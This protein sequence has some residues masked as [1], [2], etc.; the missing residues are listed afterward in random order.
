[1]AKKSRDKGKLGE[2]DLAHYLTRLGFPARRT[3]QF[4]GRGGDSADVVSDLLPSVHIEVKRNEKLDMGTA[5]LDAAMAQSESE[6]KT[7]HHAVVFWRPSKKC[8]RLTLRCNHR[9]LLITLAGD[10]N[11]KKTLEALSHID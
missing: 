6:A 9:G 11:I 1:M 10:E 5:L 4:C 3:Q 7:G 8:W 2:R